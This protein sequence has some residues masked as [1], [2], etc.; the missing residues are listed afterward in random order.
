ME[1]GKLSQQ[2]TSEIKDLLS[3]F[4]ISVGNITTLEIISNGR[5]NRSFSV[6]MHND[7]GFVSY[8]LQR[9]NTNVFKKPKELMSNISAVTGHITKKGKET[10][11]FRKV[12]EEYQKAEYGEYI[13]SD[14]G[15]CWRLMNFIESDVKNQISDA[16]DLISLGEAIGDFALT[17]SDFDASCLVE[18]IPGFHNTS[19]RLGKMVNRIA[20]IGL[21]SDAFLQTR[22]RDCKEEI[23]SIILPKR[24]EKVGIIVDAIRLG[25]IPVRVSHNDPKLNNVLFD[26]YI[27]GKVKC[28]IDLDTV[29][30]GTIL[31]DFGDAVRYACNTESEESNNP[32]KVRINLEYF[33]AFC[34]GFIPVASL[35]EREASLLIDSVWLMTYELAIR[36][37]DDHIDFNKYFGAESDGDNLRRARVQI[38]L[39]RD[40][41]K[42]EA[43]MKKI[44]SEIYF[45]KGR[46]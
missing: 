25:A 12:K 3:K 23:E 17:L 24:T 35:S 32:Q 5:I 41:E 39:L 36:F 15:A 42:N 27:V 43:E 34:E 10:L 1:F 45:S 33:K 22:C 6:T 20:T 4:E 13:Y 29:M 16:N 2:L 31:Y 11:H 9:I 14:N 46:G 21:G 26:R 40:I 30:P 8:I 37:L 38:A 7:N 18:T 44:A 19:A 28:V